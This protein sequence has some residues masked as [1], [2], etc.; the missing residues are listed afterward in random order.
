MRALAAFLR[1][2]DGLDRSREGI[3]TGLDVT[4]TPSLVLVRPRRAADDAEL[5]VWGAPASACC[6]NVS[7]TAK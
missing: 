7:S 5:E 6:S 2:A 4:V 3:V 1:V